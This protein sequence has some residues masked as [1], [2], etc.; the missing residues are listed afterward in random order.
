MLE[1]VS[2]P[3]LYGAILAAGEEEV[4]PGKEAD[5]GDAVLV[6]KDG[7]MAVPK[8]EPP[9][10]KVLVSRTAH[11]Q[12]SILSRKGVETC[13]HERWEDG[14]RGVSRAL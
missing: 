6:T 3:A 13:M 14:V 9:E 1:V 2:I 12:G 11:Q 8:V 5:A 4:R 7:L 10:T